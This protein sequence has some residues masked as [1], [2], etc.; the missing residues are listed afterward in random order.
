VTHGHADH[1]SG[2]P[3]IAA[4][5]PGVRVQKFPWR[6]VDE[7]AGVGWEAL[8][9]ADEVRLGDDVLRVVHTPGH[10]P[11]HLVFWD[12]AAR[13]AFTGDLVVRGGSVMIHASRGGKLGQYLSSLERVRQLGAVRLLPAHGDPIDDPEAILQEYLAHRRMRERQVVEAL[14]AGRRTVQAIADSIYHG[15]DP[16]SEAGRARRTCG[17]HLDKL[18]DDGRA[19]EDN[20]IMDNVIDFINVNRDRYID[21]LK[22]LLA[23]P[24]IS[25]LPEHK[26]DVRRCAEWCADE[27]RR[28]GLQNVRLVETPGNPVVYGDWLGASGAPTILFYGHYD[29]QPVDPLNLWESPP[30]EAT[31]R[32]GEIYARGAADDRARCSCTSRRRG[33]PEAKRPPAGEHQDHSRRRGRGRQRKPRRFHPRPQGRAHRRRRRDIGFRDVRARC[34]VDLL[35]PARPGVFPDRPARQQHGSAFRIVRRRRRQP[36]LRFVPDDFADEGSQRPHQDSRLLRRR[37]RAAGRGAAGMGVAAV[38]R[39]EVQEG[40][41]H[42]EIVRAK[43]ATRRSSAPG[44]GR[45]SK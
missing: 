25:A 38:Q 1:A 7:A 15:L 37:G 5:H 6:G 45:R 3:A 30:F 39:E 14:A 4:A 17:A 16:A 10:S 22:A 11:D 9:D 28:I 27:M 24:S 33:V 31:V 43:P 36:R 18:K 44:C 40:F 20:G 2:A 42:S 12:P 23:I 29:V 21:E 41:R 34:A 32:D 13:T 26:D 35:R 8:A 19:V